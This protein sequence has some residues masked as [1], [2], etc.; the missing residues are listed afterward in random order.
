MVDLPPI[1]VP[2]S[3]HRIISPTRRKNPPAMADPVD[4]GGGASCQEIPSIPVICRRSSHGRRKPDHVHRNLACGG[5][6]KYGDARADFARCESHAS[7]AGTSLATTRAVGR[8]T[9]GIERQPYR[10]VLVR[11]YTPRRSALPKRLSVCDFFVELSRSGPTTDPRGRFAI[12]RLTLFLGRLAVGPGA[13]RH[14]PPRLG[15]NNFDAS[16]VPGW[17]AF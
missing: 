1:G 7:V 8:R 14:T 13:F 15:R 6:V 3:I 10:H 17:G 9:R 2:R 16:P 5:L 4:P 11:P 12:S